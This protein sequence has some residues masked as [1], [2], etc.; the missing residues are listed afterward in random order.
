MKNSLSY[1][2]SLVPISIGFMTLQKVAAIGLNFILTYLIINFGSKEIYGEFMYLFSL[3]MMASVFLKFGYDLSYTKWLGASANRILPKVFIQV[4]GLIF[5]LSMVLSVVLWIIYGK[6][7]GWFLLSIPLYTLMLLNAGKLRGIKLANEAYFFA[8]FGR[9][10]FLVIGVS[11]AIGLNKSIS[12]Q[13]LSWIYWVSVSTLFFVSLY[14]VLKYFKVSSAASVDLKVFHQLNWPIGLSTILFVLTAWGDRFALGFLTDNTHLTYYDIGL[15]IAMM[16]GIITEITNTYFAPAFS[17]ASTQRVSLQTNITK[18]TRINVMVNTFILLVILFFG[19]TIIGF[20]NIP[21]DF[22]FEVCL[23]FSVG[24]WISSFFGPV[25]NIVQMTGLMG[26]F[27]GPFFISLCICMFLGIG[28]TL[29]LDN[30]LFMAM[31]LALNM[32]VI[33]VWGRH[34]L[35]Q[36]KGV[37]SLIIRRNVH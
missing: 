30:I 17:K 14:W 36:E 22:A 6:E 28:L 13:E 1:L 32:V 25:L 10:L 37:D 23:I 35:I 31:G 20:F 16:M 12:F 27:L 21:V 34:I 15:K 29:Y 26:K 3:L 9:V 11:V 18:A 4:D 19:K 8:S 5:I 24:Y 7:Y 2:Q 33:S